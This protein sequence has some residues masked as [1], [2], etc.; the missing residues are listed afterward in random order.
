[1]ENC[2]TPPMPPPHQT[3]TTPLP[4]VVCVFMYGNGLCVD[5]WCLCLHL[6]GGGFG[7]ARAGDWPQSRSPSFKSF[8][9]LFSC[10]FGFHLQP[11]VLR[12]IRQIFLALGCTH[13][14]RQQKKTERS[15]TLW[16]GSVTIL[17]SP[18]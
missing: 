18:G 4:C 9:A 16:S 15:V 13:T 6:K 7:K 8:L 2:V 11:F 12:N 1:M 3:T 5:S 10:F 14:Q 17:N